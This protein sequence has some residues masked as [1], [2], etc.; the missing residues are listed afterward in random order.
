M[1]LPGRP[2]PGPHHACQAS[3]C[4]GDGGAGTKHRPTVSGTSWNDRHLCLD[5][6]AA[7]LGYVGERHCPSLILSAGNSAQVDASRLWGLTSWKDGVDINWDEKG[8]LWED[9]WVRSGQVRSV[10]HAVHASG[11]GGER[12]E[13]WHLELRE[14]PGLP[15]GMWAVCT[16]KRGQHV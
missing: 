4:A 6:P 11:D 10:M 15:V 8:H 14:R 9:N 12:M 2:L 1:D 16:W 7:S 3:A 5:L 13:Y